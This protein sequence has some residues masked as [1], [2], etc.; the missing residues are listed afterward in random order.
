MDD[1]Q[2]RLIEILREYWLFILVG[3]VGIA[4]VCVGLWGVVKPSENKVEILRQAQD[5]SLDEEVGQI[6]VDVAGEVENPGV[7]ELEK[8]SRIGEAI[9]LAGGLSEGADREWVTKYLNLASEVEDGGKVYI[10][11]QNEGIE[12]SDQGAVGSGGDVAGVSVGM[13][14]INTASASELDSLWGVG[15]AR[16]DSIITNRPYGSVEELMSKAG[17]PSNVYEEIKDEVSVY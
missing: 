14:N 7:Y 9:S 16:A 2:D 8:K 11:S 15:G 10:P 13:I 17:I 6:V 5:K 1:W 4:L 3:V 12:G